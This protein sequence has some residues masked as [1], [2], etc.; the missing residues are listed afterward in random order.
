MTVVSNLVSVNYK[1]KKDTQKLSCLLIEIVSYRLIH[2]T[3]IYSIP[4]TNK[5]NYFKVTL[6]RCEQTNTQSNIPSS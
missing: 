6:C 2:L 1:H 4:V 5:D 3:P